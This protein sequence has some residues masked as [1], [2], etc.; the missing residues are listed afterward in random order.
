VVTAN[1]DG[2]SVSVLFGR[3]RGLLGARALEIPVGAEPVQVALVDVTG[4][5]ALEIVTAN[6]TA[7]TVTTLLGPGR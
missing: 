2:D 1:A 4:D 3:G 5:G 6:R 7:A